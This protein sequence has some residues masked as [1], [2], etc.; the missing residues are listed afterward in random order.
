MAIDFTLTPEQKV[1]QEA[2]RDFA[3]NV[4]LPV[5]READEEPD[6]LRAFN[7]T[8]PAYQEAVKRGIAF[9]MLPKQYGGGGLSNVDFVIAAEEICAVDPGFATTILVNGLG[10]MPVWYYGTEEQKRRFIGAATAD[11]TGEFIVGYAASEPPGSPGGTAN[12]DA[13]AGGGAGMGVTATLDGDDYVINGR[14]YWPCNVG[15]WDNEGANLNLVV[16]RAD[17]SACGTSG[18]SAVVIE[19]GTPGITYNS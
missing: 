8:K 18:L 11:T 4:L 2:A 15:G 13:P 1:L 3:Q 9:S 10:L 16:V 6:P 7:L 17:S 14:K 19:R 12:F 5:V